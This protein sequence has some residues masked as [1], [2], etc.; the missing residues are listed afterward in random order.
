MNKLKE[1][2]VHYGRRIINAIKSNRQK[3]KRLRKMENIEHMAK[4]IIA[5]LKKQRKNSTSENEVNT[6]N[7]II[8][9][10]E[11]YVSLLQQRPEK[12]YKLTYLIDG[13]THMA[14]DNGCD[15]HCTV[16]D[17]MYHFEKYVKAN[18][19]DPRSS[20]RE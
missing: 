3:I 5:Q 8:E 4:E 12:P 2:L 16:Y 15:Y 11:K 14:I 9:K 6:I 13:K 7:H 17:K 10:Y 1:A 18:I 19:I 20:R